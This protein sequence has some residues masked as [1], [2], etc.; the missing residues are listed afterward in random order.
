[1]IT[2]AK[3]FGC[4][5]AYRKRIAVVCTRFHLYDC[6][7]DAD[8]RRHHR[9]NPSPQGIELGTRATSGMSCTGE[10]R[11]QYGGPDNRADSGRGPTQAQGGER[12]V[13]E[14]AW[15]L[16]PAGQLPTVP[17]GSERLR[18]TPTP[19]YDDA[20]VDALYLGCSIRCGRCAR[21][22]KRIITEASIACAE[23]CACCSTVRS[24][25]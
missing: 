23:G 2:Q 14:P 13:A 24:V 15:D 9:R 25:V 18:I 16:H 10:R 1:V 22:I 19:Y 17:R 12:S 8:L 6:L 21:A 11:A 20:L 5:G 4:I 3:A 7:V